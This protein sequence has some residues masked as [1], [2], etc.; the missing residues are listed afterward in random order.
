MF[1]T[2][3][4]KSHFIIDSIID[5][6]SKVTHS[7]PYHLPPFP[8]ARNFP[9]ARNFKMRTKRLK[10]KAKKH[11]NRYFH[12]ELLTVARTNWLYKKLSIEIALEVDRDC[13]AMCE[14]ASNTEL[15]LHKYSEKT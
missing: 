4:L 1:K 8:E 9:R 2:I 15:A 11:P 13:L 12:M 14:R 10:K 6:S 5:T 3:T 7:D